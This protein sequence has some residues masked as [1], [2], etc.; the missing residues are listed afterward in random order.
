MG[1]ETILLNSAVTESACTMFYGVSQH[2]VKE[3]CWHLL[4]VVLAPAGLLMLD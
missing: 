3:A 2:I 1:P 4:L